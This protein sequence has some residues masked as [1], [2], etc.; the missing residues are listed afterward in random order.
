MAILIITLS[1]TFFF[2]GIVLI[3]A[4]GARS[5]EEE[6]SKREV[7]QLEAWEN[8]PFF[9]R[10]MTQISSPP[11]EP[12][13]DSLVMEIEQF[14]REEWDVAAQFVTEPTVENLYRRVSRVAGGN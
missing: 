14:L 1:V 11:E 2:G 8:S 7:P 13:E 5:I 10:P 9:V 4:S 12:V 3:L 6:R